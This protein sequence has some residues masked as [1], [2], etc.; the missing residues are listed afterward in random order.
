MFIV[1]IVGSS[2]MVTVSDRPLSTNLGGNPVHSDSATNPLNIVALQNNSLSSSPLSVSSGVTVTTTDF[3]GNTRQTAFN[4]GDLNGASYS[5]SDFVSP[6]DSNDFYR[7]NLTSDTTVNLR[8]TGLSGD[9]DLYLFDSAGALVEVSNEFGSQN[10]S[11]DQF[12]AAGT[13][14]AQ[15]RSF[16]GEA[17]TAYRINITAGGTAIDPGS[18]PSTAYDFGTL[19]R[20]SWAINEF[21]G[22]SDS[23]DYYRFELTENG[24]FSLDLTG[25]SS[26]LDVML[27]DR[28]GNL[29]DYSLNLGSQS[30]SID[31][32]LE[33][34]SYSI[35]VYSWIGSSNYNLAVQTGIPSYSGN[36]ILSGTLEADTFDVIGNYTRTIISGNGNL[37]FGLGRFDTLDLSSLLSTS[38]TL[39]LANTTG[40][41]VFYNPGNGTRVFDSIL[42]S[43]GR[44]ILFE[45]VDR[46]HF[47]DRCI[48]LA[49]TPNDPLFSQQW[50]LGMMNV[51]NAW[52]FTTGSNQVMVGIEDTGLAL[53]RQGNIPEDLRWSWYSIG[54]D[55]DD[56]FS[57][58]GSSHGTLVQSVIASVSDNG[59]E[60]SGI[61]WNSETY[62]V[63]VLGNDTG[64]YSFAQATTVMA[65]YAAQRGQRL[66]INMSLG[67]RGFNQTGLDPEFE[68][69]VAAN[70]NVLFV[71][72]AG[73]NGA[74]GREGLAYPAVLARSYSNVMAIGASW[75]R[76]GKDGNVK[77]PGE[78]INY[79][80]GIPTLGILPWGS[81]Y[82]DGLTLMGPSEVL[83]R[84]ANPSYGG[85]VEFSYT[86]G[87]D[88]TSAA[89][90]NVTGVASLVWS[91]NAN[92]SATQV[93]EIMAQTATDLGAAGYDRFYGNGF[94]NA[95]AAVRRAIAIGAGYA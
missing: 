78:R 56:D 82:G 40:S 17:N 79:P 92:L 33:A 77:T 51:Q 84:E 7:F 15:T 49:I 45:G 83:A 73:N 39:N 2:I 11:I 68:A 50:N 80:N 37:D 29:I 52:R 69:V 59:I 35:R 85:D 27:Y 26:D 72:A 81:Q 4:M 12:L 18:L 89:T 32:F 14:Y 94:V 38:V 25:L 70:P 48:D 31:R 19:S 30:E 43:D 61:N 13:Y 6:A 22:R 75:G 42:L 91:A 23:I 34:G 20:S 10:E 53:N 90:P 54:N 1:Q 8:L 9:A 44:Q 86:A 46:I 87:F 95:D 28:S 67:T 55:Y 47:S 65:E 21:V 64:D 60:M 24:T 71:I 3:I 5:Y 76:S 36:R 88:G 63:D 93:R 16:F 74:L 62:V 41:G 66:V 57:S 58:S